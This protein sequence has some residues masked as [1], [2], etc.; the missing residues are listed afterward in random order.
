M[1][2][3][4]NSRQL[5][6]LTILLLLALGAPSGRSVAT[7]SPSLLQRLDRF[8]DKVVS[9]IIPGKRE[10]SQQNA[11]G[12]NHASSTT[13]GSS[14]SSNSGELAPR[15]D[16]LLLQ[17]S[18][19]EEMDVAVGS[20]RSQ[21]AGTSSTSSRQGS[22]A[23]PHAVQSIPQPI[24]LE[25]GQV[26][27]LASD[28]PSTGSA[29]QP[30]Y[31]KLDDYRSSPFASS[32]GVPDGDSVKRP[33]SV[34]T[35]TIPGPTAAEGS[36][37]LAAAPDSGPIGQSS[38]APTLANLP[39]PAN[40]T[41]VPPTALEPL[42]VE[43]TPASIVP[44]AVAT[45]SATPAA[46]R[47]EP[48]A[49]AAG[50]TGAFA[51]T[52][53]N[54]GDSPSAA[55]VVARP[56]GNKTPDQKSPAPRLGDVPNT[57]WTPGMAAMAAPALARSVGGPAVIVES[58][59]A[60]AIT[61]GQ[62]GDYEV[63]ARNVGQSPAEQV[64][65]TV[66][67]PLWAEVVEQVA[68]SGS[69]E[70]NNQ[71]E[72]RLIVWKIERLE[73]RGDAR[74]KLKLIPRESKSIELALHYTLAAPVAETKIQ[75]REPKLEI[76]VQGPPKILLGQSEVY[77]LEVVNI[78]NGEASNVTLALLPQGTGQKN[79]ATQS[80]GSIPPGER[81]VIELELLPRQNGPLSIAIDAT[82]EGGIHAHLDH[83]ISVVQ[84]ALEVSLTGPE[85][86]FV[87]QE[88]RYQIVV[89]NPGTAPAENVRVTLT[90][91]PGLQ[92][93]TD[94]LPAAQ[95][96]EGTVEWLIPALEAGAE[97]VLEL[98]CRYQAAGAAGLA[99]QATAEGNLS[100]QSQLVTQI[101]AVADLAL[102]VEDPPRPVPLGEEAVYRIFVE[103]RGSKAA[104]DIR[105]VAFFSEGIEPVAASGAE[106][107]IA[108]GQVIFQP[109]AKI[110]PG[111]SVILAVRAKAERSGNHIFR[112][113]LQCPSSDIRLVAEETTRYYAPV[114]LA[115]R[116]SQDAAKTR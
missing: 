111:Q 69:S 107:R 34:A 113:E 59:G 79:P 89:R 58:T 74:L 85:L 9:T 71:G 25:T 81:R 116:P 54:S 109:I 50:A 101:Q 4:A 55:A 46:A 7:E 28:L 76:H 2:K 3:M 44:P 14:G 105:I 13:T 42:T 10:Q 19:Q 99:L 77:R 38:G 51:S 20:G 114:N 72:K 110:D 12:H 37:T 11:S 31:K 86:Q 29:S 1:S 102:R 84:P 96:S 100:A 41:V 66:Q 64:T 83:T 53:K 17:A 68:V 22:S 106:H 47:P 16:P 32:S 5:G 91:P 62:P 104:N 73:P 115:E 88:D 63:L 57:T 49:T 40:P 23:A 52:P 8:G 70:L 30:L 92:L 45:K 98:P 78:G 87:D 26:P 90:C 108:P 61:L 112:A 27:A 43:P 39:R 95:V 67:L 97:K 33:A 6:W 18:P 103:N 80:L 65:V 48:E 21:I 36:H 93:M 24:P 75:V 94:K 35:A 56:S 60:S 15:P 82:A